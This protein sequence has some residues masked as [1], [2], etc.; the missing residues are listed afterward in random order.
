MLRF[1][2]LKSSPRP[3]CLVHLIFAWLSLSCI[4]ANGQRQ[5]AFENLELATDEL[6]ITAGDRSHKIERF[7]PTTRA[8]LLNRAKTKRSL[9]NTDASLVFYLKG[10]PRTEYTRR[11]LSR[12]VVLKINSAAN[13][14]Q[15]LKL[16][17]A[18][19]IERLPFGKNLYHLQL[20]DSTAALNI[21]EILSGEKGIVS[22]LPQLGRLY[23]KKTIPN[24]LYFKDQWHLNAGSGQVDINVISAWDTYGGEG[25]TIGIV[26]DG[27]DLNH[28]DLA[29]N[30]A[31]G[32]HY[33]YFDGDADPSPGVDD[34]HGTAVA[35]LA[36]AHSSF[37]T[38][39]EGV[40][41]VAPMSSLAGI[42]LISGYTTDLQEALALT[43]RY[44]K[45]DIFN[46]SWGPFDDGTLIEGPLTLTSA[47]LEKSI[48]NGRTGKGSIFVFAA[49]NGLESFDN[50]N[51]DGYANSPY[52]IAVA[53][54][55][56]NGSQAYYSEPGA[57]ILIAAPADETLVTTDV[58]GSAGYDT[59]D[60]TNGFG[61]TSG[62]TPIVSG[63][64]AL[65]LEAN[66]N[67][68]WRDVQEI[69]ITT[70]IKND[71]NDVTGDSADGQISG[72]FS[73]GAGLH[74]NHKYG[75]GLLD[76]SAAVGL[77]QNW[78]Q[79]GP[80]RSTAQNLTETALL[81]APIPDLLES[82]PEEYTFDFS[83]TDL[84]LE[85]VQLTLSCK[86]SY[87]GDLEVTLVSPSKTE[88]LLLSMSNDNNSDIVD[89]TF[90]SNHFWAEEAKGVWTL[91]IKDQAEGD[92]GWLT[93]ATLTLH[94]TEQGSQAIPLRPSDF[95]AT[96]NNDSIILNWES[97]ISPVTGYIIE[98]SNGFQSSWQEIARVTSI[99]NSYV[100][101]TLSGSN[102]SAWYRIKAVNGES[103]SDYMPATTVLNSISDE[104]ILYETQFD[105][106]EGFTAGAT[107]AGQ[108]SW[109]AYSDELFEAGVIVPDQFTVLGRPGYDQ[110]LKI[111]GLDSPAGS[112]VGFTAN[113]Y[114]IFSPNSEL[115][116]SAL[117][118]FKQADNTIQERYGFYIWNSNDGDLARIDFD[119]SGIIYCYDYV[120]QQFRE[121][122]KRFLP[123]TF[124][125]L[126]LTLN[127]ELGTFNVWLNDE[128]VFTNVPISVTT[129][130]NGASVI[131]IDP[132]WYLW[133]DTAG[134]T[135]NYLLIDN[136]AFK[137]TA[138]RNPD[139]PTAVSAVPVGADRIQVT[140]LD[141]NYALTTQYRVRYKENIATN[142]TEAGVQSAS[143]LT[144]FIVSGLSPTTSYDFQIRGE[145]QVGNSP[146]SATI[147]ATTW[148]EFHGWLADN[149]YDLNADLLSDDDND[150]IPLLMEYALNLNP[151]QF[152]NSGLPAFIFDNAEHQLKLS[153]TKYKSDV[154]YQVQVS[155]DLVT[156]DAS[157]VNQT[158]SVDGQQITAAV[159]SEGET[160]QFLRLVITR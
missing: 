99:T 21:I 16:T 89:W 134:S 128:L 77:A 67:L 71:P 63:A 36:A 51:R 50:S 52:T 75:A 30:L 90:M 158:Y 79:L 108:N 22:T 60:Y 113:S 39:N 127:Q 138:I 5:T 19:K 55:A 136:Y 15:I 109:Y 115:E 118:Y 114:D 82:G 8:N 46:N 98:R 155:T 150:A 73:N 144:T 41:G 59:G 139:A 37:A 122:D 106:I 137:E 131:T 121:S 125:Q 154:A 66:S 102:D 34:S 97:S 152:S 23:S 70:A 160:A 65:I 42:R 17:G 74:F 91:R 58:V 32:L 101:N 148:T 38:G 119:A 33:D 72:W 10:K 28:P 156:W 78:T 7:A 105:A 84:R 159:N 87:R 25:I 54:L 149:Q 35:G 94:G 143:Q 11:V 76:V 95:T 151:Q 61:G 4:T 132:Y 124:I 130:I 81:P 64:I 3:I 145:N 85:H 29:P 146:Y 103:C 1:L 93:Q 45:I 43:H 88:S 47:A 18:T 24:D 96:A 116:F 57:N 126:K 86:H 107:I 9:A 13:P 111:G 129:E 120:N 49:G 117:L 14:Q 141:L 140:W 100:D 53:A 157:G 69:L 20:S 31:K 2:Y 26:D 92:T 27:L 135:I 153:Y 44:D 110:Q 48:Q 68:G 40:V 133:G 12:D 80:R 142:W 112:L 123:N 62:A 83:N 56:E 104:R 147:S 6:L